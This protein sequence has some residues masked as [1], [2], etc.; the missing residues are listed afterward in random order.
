MKILYRAMLVAI[1]AATTSHQAAAQPAAPQTAAPQPGL[2]TTSPLTI[3]RFSIMA[4]PLWLFAG[5][6]EVTVAYR[7][8]QQVGVAVLANVASKKN[9]FT[10]IE[11]T[12]GGVGA[13]TQYYLLGSFRR[14]I[15]IGGQLRYEYFRLVDPASTLDTIITEQA[16]GLAGPF[17][18]IKTTRPSG[19]T[20]E[21]QGGVNFLLFHTARSSN[22]VVPRDPLTVSPL[23][24]INLGYSF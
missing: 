13:N 17:I 15:A 19:F 5:G 22:G 7:I 8:H 1:T 9:D 14:G 11:H 3:P 6:L 12:Q 20:I 2:T 16:L 10:K 24:N 23:I 18:G 21:A 4:G